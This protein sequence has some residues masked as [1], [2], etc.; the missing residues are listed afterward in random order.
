MSSRCI[1]TDRMNF[2]RLRFSRDVVFSSRGSASCPE[3]VFF[4]VGIS[5]IFFSGTTPSQAVDWKRMVM[6]GPLIEGHEK[7]EKD[8]GSC[9]LAFEDDAQRGLCLTCH[10]LVADDLAGQTGFHGRNPLALNGQCRSCHPDHKGR[11]ADI[12]GLSE[13]TFD[14]SQTDYPLRGRHETV[15]CGQCHLPEVARR[16]APA[17]CVTCHRAEDLHGDSMSDDCSQCHEETSWR[18]TRFDH[19]TTQYPLTGAHKVA[20]CAGCHVAARY[21]GTAKDCSSCH[22]IDDSHAGRFG[23]ACADCHNTESWRRENFDHAAKSKFSLRGAH[24]QTSCVTCHRK[25]P[26][27]RKLPETCSGCHA[28]EDVHAG[29]FGEACSTCHSSSTWQKTFFDHTAKTKFELRGAHSRTTC[30]ACHTQRMD[31]KVKLERECYACHQSDD[32]HR[33]ELGKDCADCHNEDSFPGR[34]LFDHELTRFPLLGLHAISSC[35]S[36]HPDHTFKLDDSSCQSC[37]AAEDVHKKT[38]GTDCAQ[39]HNPN[40][41]KVWRFNHDK[42]TAFALHGEHK[43]LECSACHRA[44]MTMRVRPSGNCNDCHASQDVHRGG[45]G[46]RCGACHDAKA[47]KPAHFGRSGVAKE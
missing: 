46:R 44:P 12:S 10:K 25:P 1:S 7:L 27:E 39:C 34:V 37:H 15:N 40:G 6:P 24:A 45:F 18:T 3:W 41:W 11:R 30:N 17:D 22:G 23:S 19:V 20:S 43:G 36:C 2:V 35:E 14:H 47:W 13:A 26:G 4:L 32:V 42:Q 29:R 28:S 21:K 9:H 5:M 38:L 33:G 31:A 16:D 8:C